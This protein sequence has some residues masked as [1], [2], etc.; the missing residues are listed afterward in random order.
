V[1]V[2]FIFLPLLPDQKAEAQARKATWP[3]RPAYGVL[4]VALM[5][6]SLLY[7]IVVSVLAMLPAT[8]CLKLVGGDGC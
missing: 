8:M 4:T 3:S 6:S 2:A 5:G 1:L 7:A